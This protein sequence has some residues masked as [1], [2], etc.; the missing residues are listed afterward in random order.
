M[1]SNLFISLKAVRNIFQV[2]F[3][4]SDRHT[5][6][7]ARAAHPV[8]CAEGEGAWAAAPAGVYAPTH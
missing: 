1:L 8:E 3:M 5:T 4:A 6:C 2:G 7:S